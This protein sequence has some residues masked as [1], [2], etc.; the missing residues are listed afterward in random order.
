MDL[1]Q[2]QFKDIFCN[3]F[4]TMT[5]PI[6]SNQSNQ[7]TVISVRGSVID[8]HFPQKLP[9]IHNL[10][11][12]GDNGRIAVEVETHLSAEVIRGV[13]LTLTQ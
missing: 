6:I 11:R 13:A 10:L 2:I 7:G 3:V 8:A 9:H 4:I 12:T 1:A 5:E